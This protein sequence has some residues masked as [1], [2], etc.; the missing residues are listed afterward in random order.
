M[1]KWGIVLIGFGVLVTIHDLSFVAV[2]AGASL[3]YSPLAGPL[4]MVAGAVVVYR[5]YG[6]RRA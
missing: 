4:L 6:Q 3:L 5:G 2:M 1:T